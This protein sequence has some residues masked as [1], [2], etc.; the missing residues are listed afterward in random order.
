VDSAD[1]AFDARVKKGE[2]SAQTKRNYR[3]ALCKFFTWL[4]SQSWYIEQI[5]PPEPK[6]KPKKAYPERVPAR[7]YSGQRFYALKEE[8]LTLEIQLDLKRYEELEPG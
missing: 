8:E 7:A 1:E 5:E 6:V 3:S 2:V 4:Q